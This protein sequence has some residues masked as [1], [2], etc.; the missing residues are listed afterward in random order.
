MEEYENVLKSSG[1]GALFIDSRYKPRLQ[2]SDYLGTQQPSSP[3]GRAN[4]SA[5]MPILDGCESLVGKED[6]GQDR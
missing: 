6:L 2:F 4:L 3:S 5:V 1:L